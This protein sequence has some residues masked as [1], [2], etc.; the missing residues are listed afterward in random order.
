MRR[1]GVRGGKNASVPRLSGQKIPIRHRTGFR[2]F[3]RNLGFLFYIKRRRVF[4]KGTWKLYTAAVDRRFAERR[5]IFV[6]KQRRKNAG[7][8]YVAARP[9]VKTSANKDARARRRKQFA[10]APDKF[11]K[12]FFRS[13][14]KKRIPLFYYRYF[15]A[16]FF[17]YQKII[18]N[19]F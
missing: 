3:E 7:A 2:S 6:R 4:R 15:T 10:A 14:S 9:F 12:G 19:V 8:A 18:E 11:K 5:R 16:G 17:Q 1:K 13:I